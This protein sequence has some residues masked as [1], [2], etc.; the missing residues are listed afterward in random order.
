GWLT[1]FRQLIGAYA[2][3]LLLITFGSKLKN[4]NKRYA[5][6]LPG[7]GVA[8]LFLSAYAGHLYFK[9]YG[10]TEAVLI[11]GIVSLAALYLF[12]IFASDLLLVISI[13]GSYFVP[14]LI[15][16]VSS[17][18]FNVSLYFAF[19]GVLYSLCSI[20]LQRRILISVTSYFAIVAFQFCLVEVMDLSQAQELK[21]GISLQLVQFIVFSFAI[22]LFSVRW[23]QELTSSEAWSLFPALFIFYGFEYSMLS[24]LSP[25]TAPWVSFLFAI[26]LFV[27]YVS[28]KKRLNKASLN[29]APM[30]AASVAMI[31]FHSVYFKLWP[32]AFGV[33]LGLLG[34]L[35]LGFLKKSGI[36]S[37]R[38]S[39]A[40]LFLWIIICLEYCAALGTRY[41]DSSFDSI[42]FAL[43]NLAF[44][45]LIAYAY[46]KEKVDVA[47]PSFW[48]LFFAA[49]QA[50]HGLEKVAGLL[51]IRPYSEYL[52]SALW[53]ILAL[54]SLGGA[55]NL[56]DKLLAR[57]AV[58]I[59]WIVSAK[60][61]LSDLS[62]SSSIVRIIT[63]CIVGAILYASGLIL[64]KFNSLEA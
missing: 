2:F 64:K 24:D 38:F 50:L 14:V 52:C 41:S 46:A 11:A 61:L 22:F 4:K 25:K 1:P 39:I 40:F 43:E 53:A 20:L 47:T 33:E 37:K 59:L 35:L 29:S 55:F 34:V 57:G 36:D 30:I 32:G 21:W 54:L 16:N 49:L 3:G 27:L 5:S 10:S 23:K 42:R 48:L 63:L 62:A 13:A 51:V 45:G 6:L 31:L 58:L 18:V 9:F 7:A 44:A 12:T 19:W 28:A 26:F 56:K 15:D 60:V 17:T 8:I